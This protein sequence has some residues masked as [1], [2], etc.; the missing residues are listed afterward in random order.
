MM[1]DFKKMTNDWVKFVDESSDKV[2]DFVTKSTKD[3]TGALKKE[4]RKMELRSQI[5][6]HTRALTKAY[7]RLGEA[8]YDAKTSGKEVEGMQDVMDL[9]HS[10]RKV[11]E[12]LKAQLE[13]L[14]KTD[15]EKK[16]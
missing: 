6:E 2:A 10:N 12:L 9:V 13:E 4:R 3:M 14:E 7:T 1:E 11:V 5:G 8:Y 15:S 16:D